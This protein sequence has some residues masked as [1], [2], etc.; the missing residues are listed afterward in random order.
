MQSTEFNDTGVPDETFPPAGLESFVQPPIPPSA[1]E[2]DFAAYQ[3]WNRTKSKKDMGA[4]ITQLNPVIYSEVHRQAGTLPPAALA[5]ETKIWAI[6][7]I[8]SYDPSKGAALAT[9]VTNYIRRVRR[10]NYKY[11]NNARLPDPVQM[12]VGDYKRTVANLSEELNRE[13]TTEEISKSLGWTK[14]FA[15]KFKDRLYDDLVESASERSS[16]TSH[17]SD[18]DVLLREIWS[19]LT[20]DEKVIW[21]NK[22]DP[23]EKKEWLSKMDPEE[24]SQWSITQKLSAP[25]LAIKLKIDL[26]ALNYMQR[27]LVNKISSLKT[28]MGM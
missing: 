18:E 22:L 17:Y 1:R 6:K 9:H 19:K 12:K 25:Q 28:E 13:P 7:A 5:G 4:L 3:Q 20:Q 8:K 10:L 2:K 24:Q 16:E 15:V 26:N 23:A 11:Q 14:G 27:K 21:W